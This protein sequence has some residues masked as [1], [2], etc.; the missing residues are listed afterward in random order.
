VIYRWK[1]I[2]QMYPTGAENTFQKMGMGLRQSQF[3]FTISKSI[4]CVKGLNR[5][6]RYSGD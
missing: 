3:V 2:P 1:A 6:F 4:V 5:P